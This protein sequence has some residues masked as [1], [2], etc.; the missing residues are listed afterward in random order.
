[1]VFAVGPPVGLAPGA[2]RAGRFLTG[3]D[4]FWVVLIRVAPVV[5]DVP[6]D[7]EVRAVLLAGLVSA[8][9]AVFFVARALGA[10][11]FF[12]AVFFVAVFFVAVLVVAVFFVAVF[13]AVFCAD[14]FGADVFL[15]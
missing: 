12:V 1:M 2:F 7:L 13:A 15:G 9:V 6:A 10:A 4:F 14:V 8:F 3:S 11:V 5:R